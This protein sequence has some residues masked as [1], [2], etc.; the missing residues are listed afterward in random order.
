MQWYLGPE[1]R[2]SKDPSIKFPAYIES[3]RI[4]QWDYAFN[5]P[6]AKKEIQKSNE[7]EKQLHAE[8]ASHRLVYK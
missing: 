5:G 1:L 3:K 8:P 2:T 4:R 7:W 6:I